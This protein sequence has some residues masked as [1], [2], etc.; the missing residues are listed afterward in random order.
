MTIENVFTKYYSSA[1]D[2]LSSERFYTFFGKFGSKRCPVFSLFTKMSPEF[3]RVS[4]NTLSVAEY[5]N[6]ST[7]S[8]RS[9][10]MFLFSSYSK[11]AY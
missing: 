7:G 1:D 4:I 3:F 10:C 8:E 5:D 9:E 6:S 2:H 11:I